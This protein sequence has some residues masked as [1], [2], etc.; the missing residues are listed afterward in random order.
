MASQPQGAPSGSGTQEP[1]QITVHCSGL[2]PG[3][4]EGDRAAEVRGRQGPGS[5]DPGR[6]TIKTFLHLHSCSSANICT[7]Q[8]AFVAVNKGRI[9]SGQN[10]PQGWALHQGAREWAV[11]A[12]WG[13]LKWERN[14]CFPQW[15]GVAGTAALAFFLPTWD[16]VCVSHT[17]PGP[18]GRGSAP[19]RGTLPT[20]P[21]LLPPRQGDATRATSGTTESPYHLRRQQLGV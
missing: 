19:A 17:C 9:I 4:P 12:L 15:W 6:H 13:G 20:L 11:R 2:G 5:G 16:T 8:Q 3:G 21:S 7:H 10:L 18:P 14:F 1:C